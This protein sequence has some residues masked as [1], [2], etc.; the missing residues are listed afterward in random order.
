VGTV[1][2]EVGIGGGGSGSGSAS[3]QYRY[4][5]VYHSILVYWYKYSTT[6]RR[7]RR[8]IKYS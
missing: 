5:T 4:G 6:G 1:V 7:S 3:V 2:G 8:Q